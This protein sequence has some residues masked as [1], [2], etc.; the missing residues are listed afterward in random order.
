MSRDH[1]FDPRG[2]IALPLGLEVGQAPDVVDLDVYLW[3]TQ[4]AGVGEEEAP[5]QLGPRGG[6]ANRPEAATWASVRNSIGMHPQ[7]GGQRECP[8]AQPTL[9]LVPL[10]PA[11]IFL[12]PG[13]G[14]R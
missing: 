12:D 6:Q 4:L 7:R 2:P 10:I 13:H 5:L 8:R 11:P 14:R 1:H 9:V 3:A